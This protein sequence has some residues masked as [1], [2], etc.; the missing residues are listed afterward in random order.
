MRGRAELTL[1]KS[2]TLR[3]ALTGLFG[4]AAIG[5]LIYDRLL[6]QGKDHTGYFRIL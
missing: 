6:E 3:T 5:G 2:L 4:A 1:T